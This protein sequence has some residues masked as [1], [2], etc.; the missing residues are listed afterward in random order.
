[1]TDVVKL[2]S[3]AET[4]A[5]QVVIEL[6][7]AGDLKTGIDAESPAKLIIT[8]HKQLTEHFSRSPEGSSGL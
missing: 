7:R 1:M 6:I 4:A 5:L 3:T 8:A 2:N